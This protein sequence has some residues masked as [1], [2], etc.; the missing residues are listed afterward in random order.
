MFPESSW[1]PIQTDDGW[2]TNWAISPLF[3]FSLP[4]SLSLIQIWADDLYLDFFL[5]CWLSFNFKR[6]HRMYAFFP[7]PTL[8]IDRQVVC[9]LVLSPSPSFPSSQMTRAVL[10]WCLLILIGRMS[11][12]TRRARYLLCRM[13]SKLWPYCA[14]FYCG[15]VYK[16]VFI[17]PFCG[18]LLQ[19]N[20]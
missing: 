18:A 5:S 13:T 6:L 3:L 10:V 4:L 16:K 19:P 12:G 14:S 15:G 17:F 2:S 1:H 20:F 7:S 9:F 11:T 8:S